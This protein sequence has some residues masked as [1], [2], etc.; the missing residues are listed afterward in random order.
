MDTAINL[1]A[2]LDVSDNGQWYVSWMW[3]SGT[4]RYISDVHEEVLI[5]HSGGGVLDFVKGEPKTAMPHE[6]YLGNGSGHLPIPPGQWTMVFKVIGEGGVMGMISE[7]FYAATDIDP[8]D[9]T[10]PDLNPNPHPSPQPRPQPS[11]AH[12]PTLRRGDKSVDGWVEYLQELLNQSGY[13][14]LTVDGDFG[15]KTEA[16]VKAFQRDKGLQYDG[17][18]GNQTWAALRGEEPEAPGSDG[19]TPHTYVERGPE[20]RWWMDTNPAEYVADR[21][22]LYLL[23]VNTGDR[24]IQQYEFTA[25]VELT[26]EKGAATF[27]GILVTSDG[28]PAAPGKG[29]FFVGGGIRATLGPGTYTITATLPAELGGDVGRETITIA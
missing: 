13:G 2:N 18:V 10:P 19:R 4:D 29:L 12:E 20:A 3:T 5:E 11:S 15:G 26:S 22:A 16:A 14:P 28:Q 6:T 21:D 9:H 25:H 23:A 8:P 1:E 27:E 17:D 7:S 24:A